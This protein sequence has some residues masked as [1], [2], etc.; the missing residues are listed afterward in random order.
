M[1]RVY[2]NRRAHHEYEL[3]ERFEAGIALTGSE[4]KSVRAGGVDF[5]DAFAR[6]TG[7]N[8][9]LEGLYIPTYTEATYNNHEPRR[10]RR[11]LLHR[12]EIGKLKRALEQ[13]GLTLVPTRLYQKGRVFK[14]ELALARGKKLHDKRR[15]EAEKTLRRELREL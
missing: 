13:K 7:G 4:V 15:A 9:E 6:L 2:T 1:P 14:V 3:L 12:E 5:R 11:L 8:I 10:P